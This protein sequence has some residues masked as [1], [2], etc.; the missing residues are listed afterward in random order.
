MIVILLLIFL[1][2][3]MSSFRSVRRTTVTM[4]ML[5]GSRGWLFSVSETPL[6]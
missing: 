6:T 3:S 5:K 4:S 2:Q 1:F